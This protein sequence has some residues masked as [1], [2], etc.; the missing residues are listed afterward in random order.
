MLE[1][2]PGSGSADATK[3]RKGPQGHAWEAVLRPTTYTF[4]PWA[5]LDVAWGSAGCVVDGAESQA[6]SGSVGAIC[7]APAPFVAGAGVALGCELDWDWVGR[8]GSVAEEEDLF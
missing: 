2:P 3:G 7:F 8:K 6:V 4:L 5:G 1:A